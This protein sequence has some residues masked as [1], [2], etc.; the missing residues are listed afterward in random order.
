MER[1]QLT[2]IQVG[3]HTA[4]VMEAFRHLL[5][6]K[7]CQFQG[8]LSS[9][10]QCVDKLSQALSIARHVHDDGSDWLTVREHAGAYANGGGAFLEEHPWK[11]A[12]DSIRKLYSLLDSYVNDHIPPQLRHLYDDVYG[13]LR[14]CLDCL[15]FHGSMNGFHAALWEAYLQ[16]GWPCGWS[17][18]LIE[19]DDGSYDL[20]GSLIYVYWENKGDAPN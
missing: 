5:V 10:Y 13:D 4:P 6:T 17:G 19:H 11:T 1:D 12:E 8:K 16:G 9:P 7:L 20:S 18:E 2:G 15:I 3:P 14:S